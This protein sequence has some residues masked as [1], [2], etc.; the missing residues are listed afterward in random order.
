MAAKKGKGL[1]KLMDLSDEMAGFMGKD[2]ASR[3]DITKK[4]W[5]YIKKHDL[6]DENDR[7]TII[8][9]DVLA[10]ILGPRPISMFKIATK[11]SDHVFEP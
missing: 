6:Q 7:R 4:I 1:S 5:D 3:A 9:D 11:V 10:E 8:P 2:R